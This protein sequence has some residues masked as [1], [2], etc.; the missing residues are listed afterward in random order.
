MSDRPNVLVVLTDQQRWDTLGCYGGPVATPNADRLAEEGTLFEQ[1]LTPQPLCGPARSCLQTGRY[2][3]EHGTF[4]NPGAPAGTWPDYERALGELFRETGYDT[5]YVGKWHV[6]GAGTDPVGPDRRMGYEFWRAADALEH[7]SHPYEG[8]LYD[9]EGAPVDLDGYRVDAVTDI[10]LDFIEEDREAPFFCFLS[11]LEPHHQNDMD[12]YV[13]P[14][15]G[16]YEHRNARVPGDLRGRPGGSRINWREE[17]PGYYGVCQR[18]DEQLGRLLDAVGEDTLVVFTSD[19]G[20]HFGTRHLGNKCSPHEASVRVPL[21]A[22]GPGF[23]GGGTV[24]ELVSLLDVPPTLLGAAGIDAPADYA[25]RSLRPLVDGAPA[26]RDDLFVQT[27]VTECGRA[28]RTDRWKYAVHAPDADPRQ[29]PA[30]DRYVERYLYDLRADPGERTNLAG[31][32]DYRGVADR[33]RERL[34]ERIAE[35]E[36]AEPTIARAGYPA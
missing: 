6:A 2:A 23:E 19:H 15:G 24:R 13:A 18:V 5:G 28:L 8:T 21:V 9:E 34:G 7:T 12:A 10:A 1:A 14:E 36:G 27:S 11:H 20:C 22:G 16:A 29:D 26:W 3:T 4:V 32:G 17:L 25:G 31:R 33:L 30:A 35:V